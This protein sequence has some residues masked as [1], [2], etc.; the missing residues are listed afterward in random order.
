MALVPMEE[1]LKSREKAWEAERRDLEGKAEE[2]ARVM[3]TIK[4]RC[5]DLEKSKLEMTEER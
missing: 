1:R 4:E 3:G 5:R 2:S